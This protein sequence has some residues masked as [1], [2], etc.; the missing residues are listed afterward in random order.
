MK[1]IT[2]DHPR[3]YDPLVATAAA[4]SRTHPGVEIAWEKRPLQAFENQPLIQLCREFDFLVIDHPHVGAIARNRCMI[5]LEDTGRDEELRIL[6]Q[7]SVGGS[8]QSY[9]YDGSQWALAIDAASQA[10]AY[11]AELLP[12]PP[13]NW[14]EVVALSSCGSVLWPLKPVHALMSF[15]TLAA[16]AGTP[17]C[18]MKHHL[19]DEQDGLAVLCMMEEV[20]R[21]IPQ[22]C[23]DLDPI[24][25]LERLSEGEDFVYCPLVFCYSNYTRR[26]FRPQLIRFRNVP[27]LGNGVARS[28]LGGAGIAV[29]SLTHDRRSAVDYAFWLAGADCQKTIYFESGGQPANRRAWEDEAVNSRCRNFFREFRT[30]M[31]QSWVR[32]RH[33]GYLEFQKLGGNIIHKFLERSR[34]AKDTIRALQSA[35]EISWGGSSGDSGRL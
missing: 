29:S 7:E 4:Y 6:E 2:W 21:N 1:G 8:H 10:S 14:R 22:E 27:K 15:F 26:G 24:G 17:C 9:R 5:R 31:D 19:L 11:R 30:T 34:T 23:L 28:T 35:Y 16:S 32:P 20:F 12:C 13:S 18:V 33:A 3:G 25:V